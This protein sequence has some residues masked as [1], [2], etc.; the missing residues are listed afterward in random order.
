MAQQ[1][2]FLQSIGLTTED[3]RD[4]VNAQRNQQMTRERSQAITAGKQ[5]GIGLAGLTKGVVGAVRDRTFENFGR[6][7]SQGSAE[8]TDRDT[9]QQLG[10]SIEQIRGRREIRRITG[11]TA[12]N[13]GSYAARIS[14]A[15]KIAAIANRSGDTEVLAGAL[16]KIDD[17]RTEQ[18]EFRKLQAETGEAEFEEQEAGVMD[19]I[20]NG[21]P[22][23]G[24]IAEDEDGNKGLMMV[25]GGQPTFK[26]FGDELKLNDGG[27][28]NPNDL[29]KRYIPTKALSEVRGKVVTAAEHLR[30]SGRVLQTISDGL[31]ERRVQGILSTAAYRDVDALAS[32]GQGALPAE[33]PASSSYQGDLAVDAQVH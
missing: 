14:L 16:K 18:T 12:G 8:A 13:D 26:P 32:Q 29:L 20:L 23:T 25:L 17:L 15:K 28:E 1:P 22:V 27:L 10:L 3:E 9:S 4:I 7:V 6:N 33:A 11:I 5:L 2:G 21:T 24:T 30:K 31:T 19:G